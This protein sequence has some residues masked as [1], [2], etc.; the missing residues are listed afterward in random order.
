VNGLIS[1]FILLVGMLVCRQPLPLTLLYFPLAVVPLAL[2]CLGLGWFLASVGVY[3]RDTGPVVAVVLQML[4]FLTPIFYPIGAV[5]PAFQTIM[6]MNPLT[7]VVENA[8]LTIMQGR[9]PEW[10]WLIASTVLGLVLMQLGYTWFMKTK[11]GFA[12]VL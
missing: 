10:A 6:R 8:R 7:I 9:P 1:L 5:P 4:I 11:R 2:L 12:D 3:L